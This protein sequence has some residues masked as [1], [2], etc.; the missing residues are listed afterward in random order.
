R[1]REALVAALA[2]EEEPGDVH[3]HR[4]AVLEAAR[5]DGQRVDDEQVAIEREA[6]EHL[7]RRGDDPAEDV[8]QARGVGVAAAIERQLEPGAPDFERARLV[9]PDLE[10]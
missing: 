1:T 8:D 6:A 7:S 3:R 4:R 10:R 9:R 5:S 2:A